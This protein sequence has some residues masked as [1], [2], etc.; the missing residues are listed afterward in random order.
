MFIDVISYKMF[1]KKMLNSVIT[2]PLTNNNWIIKNNNIH[3]EK[4]F[5]QFIVALLTRYN[6][7]FKKCNFFTKQQHDILYIST[8]NSIVMVLVYIFN[9][10]MKEN[11]SQ[12][13]QLHK[14]T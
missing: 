12:H 14:I 7:V 5:T 2:K 3:K 9:I 1:F 6:I 8:S 11:R 10:T 4:V 13:E